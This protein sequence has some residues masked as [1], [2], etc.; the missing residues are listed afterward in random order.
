VGAVKEALETQVRERGITNVVFA[1]RQPRS[2]VARFWSVCDVSL[3]HLK[4][5]PVFSTVIPS[6][7][8]ESM[9]VGLPMVYCGPAGEGSSIVLKH[10]AGLHVSSARPAELAEAVDALSRDA[11]LR[12]RLAR[13]SAASAQHY[14]RERQAELTLEVLLK[15]AGR[16]E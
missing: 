6:K 11:E 4:D 14:S 7:I 2:E 13:N 5:D 15:A 10:D 16:A 12:S 9:A 3:I 8:F 1:P